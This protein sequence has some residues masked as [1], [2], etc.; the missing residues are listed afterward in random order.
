MARHAVGHE[1]NRGSH[2]V[3]RCVFYELKGIGREK[4]FPRHVFLLLKGVEVA[5]G[6][7]VR[8]PRWERMTALPVHLSGT[9]S[10]SSLKRSN[11]SSGGTEPSPDP[12]CHQ[13][14]TA[15]QWLKTKNKSSF[16]IIVVC[17]VCLSFSP[18]V[19]YLQIINNTWF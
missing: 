1:L 4:S 17:F 16:W 6:Y 7:E 15:I 13:C 8:P 19:Y 12:G 9:E 18:A 10:L 5:A 11:V 14:S 3:L 2:P